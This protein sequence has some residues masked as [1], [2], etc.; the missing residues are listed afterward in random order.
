MEAHEAVG[1]EPVE[2]GERKEEVTVA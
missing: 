1:S 2:A